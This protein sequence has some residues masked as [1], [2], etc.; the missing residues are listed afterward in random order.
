MIN[1]SIQEI[2]S[3]EI[4][5]SQQIRDARQGSRLVQGQIMGQLSCLTY[6]SIFANLFRNS[7]VSGVTTAG[8][9]DSVVT[10]SSTAVTIGSASSNFLTLGFKVGDGI[11]L[12]GCS[13]APAAN[14]G[15]NLLVTAVTAT[16]L[17]CAPPP[18]GSIVAYSSGQTGVIISVSGAKLTVAKSFAS[19]TTT[20]LSFESWFSDISVSELATGCRISSIGI[21]VPPSG[22]V[23]TTISFTGQKLAQNNT[24]QLTS[25]AATTSTTSLTATQGFLMLF[26]APV[27][28]ITGF[29]IQ[30]AASSDTPAVLGTP[31]TPDIFRGNLSGSGSFTALFAGDAITSAFLNETEFQIQIFMTDSSLPTAEFVSIFLPRVKIFT[32]NK[33]DNDRQIT[34]SVNFRCLEQDILGG[35]GTAYD[36]TTITIQDSLYQTNSLSFVSVPGS[37]T[38]GSAS[39]TITGTVSPASTAVVIGLS[40]SNTAQPGTFPYGATVTGNNWTVTITPPT[41]GTFYAWGVS[42][43]SAVAVSSAI[44][45]SAGSSAL[46][47]T[48]ISSSPTGAVTAMINYSGQTGMSTVMTHGSSY[49]PDVQMTVAGGS[50][51]TATGSQCWFDTSA[52]NTNPAAGTVVSGTLQSCVGTPGGSIALYNAGTAPAAG[53]YYFKQLIV[54]TGT[55]AGN[56]IFSSQAITVS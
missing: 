35:T 52:S 51:I 5:P 11:S 7:F 47:W 41:V 37:A 2:D 3:A 4:L 25:P 16:L 9:S 54:A 30:I 36:D 19:A 40:S 29:N 42:A 26:G 24:Q 14:N 6:T 32:D 27:A 31:Y 56:Y 28:Y 55:N 15:V 1:Q 21:Q 48:M 13:G 12:A 49:T 46:T 22:F 17:T 44:T 23:T 18:N 20:S 33:N 34:R 39:L 8:L 45:I 50:S 38:T 10:V 43:T 53:T